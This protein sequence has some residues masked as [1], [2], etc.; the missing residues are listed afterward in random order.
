M[1]AGFTGKA[2]DKEADLSMMPG[3]VRTLRNYEIVYQDYWF[4]S[5][6]TNPG[7][8][9]NHV[10][11]VISLDINKD[12]SH[13]DDMKPEKDSTQIKTTSPIRMWR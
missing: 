11:K 8:R 5:S 4:E 9:S 1:F 7:T 12:G 10:A 3:E 2:F 6:E 13:F